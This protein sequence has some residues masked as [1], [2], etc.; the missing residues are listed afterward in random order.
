M[1][2]PADNKTEE[3]TGVAGALR[4]Y[5]TVPRM[6]GFS[7]YRSGGYIVHT[8]FAVTAA[9]IAIEILHRVYGSPIWLDAII[10]FAVVAL[11][12]GAGVFLG[13]QPPWGFLVTVLLALIAFVLTAKS[14]PAWPSI[15]IGFVSQYALVMALPKER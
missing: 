13:Y 2:Q 10:G 1:A 9:V 5:F 6:T 3:P 12:W 14:G 11:L 4:D 7:S 8:A 15:V